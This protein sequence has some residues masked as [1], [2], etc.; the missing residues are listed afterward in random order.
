MNGNRY[1]PSGRS[2]SGHVLTM[3]CLTVLVHLCL[4]GSGHAQERTGRVQ[5]R[6][7]R[8]DGS[9]VV[10]AA[11]VLNESGATGVTGTSGQFAFS[12]LQPGT[13]SVTLTLG[14][15]SVTLSGVRVT[16]G[17][18]QTL[19]KRVDWALEFTYSLVVTRPRGRWS[20]WWMRPP[21]RR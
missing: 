11:V 19:E 6:L 1:A 13:Y 20:G 15:N 7:I 17:T 18:T 10:G 5:G 4:A 2:K 3:L 14:A 9:G 16:A 21:P 8:E 12:N